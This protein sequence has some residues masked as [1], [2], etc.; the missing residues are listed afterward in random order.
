M[1]CKFSLVGLYVLGPQEENVLVARTVLSC[2]G[3]DFAVDTSKPFTIVTWWCPPCFFSPWFFSP[4][5]TKILVPGSWYQHLGTEILVPGS[6]Y[7]DL[8][9]RIL[10][11]RSRYQ[12]KRRA[13][14]AEPLGMQGGTGGCR[15]PARGSGGL[16]AP[17]EQRGVWGAA[18]PQ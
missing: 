16:E 17:Q 13:R 18:A 10:V 3:S 2:H 9:T 5:G 8:G 6:L 11:P 7:Q 4:L 14:E 1:F 12:K 15:P